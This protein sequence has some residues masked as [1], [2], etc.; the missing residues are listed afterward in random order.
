[1]NLACA[2]PGASSISAGRCVLAV[3]WGAAWVMGTQGPVS[4]RYQ[5][6]P[7]GPRAAVPAFP[8]SSLPP[9][10]LPMGA[11]HLWVPVLLSEA[12]RPTAVAHVPQGSTETALSPI[13]ASYLVSES[14]G[15][16]KCRLIENSLLTYV[17]CE[18]LI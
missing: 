1:M 10:P 8:A 17:H 2:R 13:H 9:A 5:L 12:L 18:T 14:C 6:S 3:T 7:A 11:L 16:M 15:P 4:S